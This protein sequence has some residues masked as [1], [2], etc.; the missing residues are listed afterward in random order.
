MVMPQI[1]STLHVSL[2]PLLRRRA[3]RSNCA[4]GFAAHHAYCIMMYRDDPADVSPL[5]ECCC[6]H[7]KKPRDRCEEMEGVDLKDEREEHD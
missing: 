1:L 4:W 2:I 7:F 5:P 3:R 6:I